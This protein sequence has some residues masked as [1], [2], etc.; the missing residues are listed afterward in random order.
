MAIRVK[1]VTCPHCKGKGYHF[2][3][4]DEEAEKERQAEGMRKIL[5]E[6][7]SRS[8]YGFIGRLR[9]MRGYHK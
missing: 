1:K 4:Y 3:P 6:Q 5:T 8:F 9:Q 2:E 7:E